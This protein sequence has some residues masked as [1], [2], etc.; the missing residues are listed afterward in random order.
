M[1]F[2]GIE[3][4]SSF[5]APGLSREVWWSSDENIFVSVPVVRAGVVNVVF[6][7]GR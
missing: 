3:A 5:E 1:V 2:E 4:L 6:F 7:V